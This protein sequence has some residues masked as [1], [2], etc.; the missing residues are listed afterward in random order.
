MNEHP[1]PEEVFD[2]YALGSL[3][4]EDKQAFESHLRDCKTCA[5]RLEEARAR[6]ALLSLAAPP[7]TPPLRVR[8]GLLA[9]VRAQ[10]SGKVPKPAISRQPRRTLWLV[11]LLAAAAGALAITA[12]VLIRLNHRL[13]RQLA[14]L[15]Q[16]QAAMLAAQQE[17]Q[18]QADKARRVLNVLT[19]PETVKVSLLP[20]DAHPAPQGKAF[21]N[22]DKGLVFYAAN[23]PPPPSGYTYQLWLVPLRGVPISAGVFRTDREGDGKVV[24]PPLPRG[25]PAKAFAVTIEPAGG[26]PQPTGKKVLIGAVS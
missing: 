21:Y 10:S 8:E 23:L 18:L 22:S 5:R 25:V 9:Q 17:Q 14:A 7:I 16:K 6:L 13:S 26:R 20:A 19:S 2:E 12:V 11:P 3:E 1:Q 24:L 4:G 15:E